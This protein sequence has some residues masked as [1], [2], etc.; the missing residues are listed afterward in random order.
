VRVDGR[1]LDPREVIETMTDIPLPESDADLTVIEWKPKHNIKDHTQYLCDDEGVALHEVPAGVQPPGVRYSAY[2]K[3]KLIRKL[4]D[5][6]LFAGFEPDGLGPLVAEARAAI[7]DAH[8]AAAI[9]GDVGLQDDSLGVARLAPG[10]RG[11]VGRRGRR[12][13]VGRRVVGHGSP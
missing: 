4:E 10:G 2:L 5:Q 9:R 6:L 8:V 1:T 7:I 13:P 3:A 11:T 12:S